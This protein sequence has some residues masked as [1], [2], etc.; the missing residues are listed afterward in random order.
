MVNI[1]IDRKS[2][3]SWLGHGMVVL[4]DAS[5]NVLGTFVPEASDDEDFQELSD[6]EFQRRLNEG[7]GRSLKEILADLERLQ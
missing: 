4:Q 3:E 7:G 5:G 1:T 2:I 6:E